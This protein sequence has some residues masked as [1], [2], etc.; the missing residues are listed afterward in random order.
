M[1]ILYLTTV[2][3]KSEVTS[4]IYADLMRALSQSHSVTVVALGACTEKRMQDGYPVY[5]QKAMPYYNTS[6]LK[7]GMA[8]LFLSS[9]FIRAIKNLPD[10]S[11]DVILFETPPPTIWRAVSFAKKKYGCPAYLMLKDIAP[12]NGVDLGIYSKHSLVYHFF[13]HAE[14]KLYRTADFIGCMSEA[15]LSCAAARGADPNRLEIFENTMEVGEKKPRGDEAIRRRYH[16]PENAVVCVFGGN[17]GR[18]QALPF[19]TDAIVALKDDPRFFFVLAGRGKE[20]EQTRQAKEK[21]NLQ[22]V[23][24]LD[25]LPQQEYDELLSVSDIG[26]VL[27][28]PRFTVPNYPS[29]ILKY[30]QYSLPIVAA[31]DDATDIGAMIEKQQIGL[32]GS[33]SDLPGFIAH[34]SMLAD[35]PDLRAQMGANGFRYVSEELSVSKS[36]ELLEGLF[37]VKARAESFGMLMQ[38][39]LLGTPVSLSS[40]KYGMYLLYATAVRHKTEALLYPSVAPFLPDELKGIWESAMQKT[41]I[42]QINMQAQ[43]RKT[44]LALHDAEI[45]IIALKGLVALPMY[46]HP[47]LR[48]MGDADLLVDAKDMEKID[49]VLQSLGYRMIVHEG[50]EYVY[51]RGV[52]DLDIHTEPF[53]SV[54]YNR[55]RSYYAKDTC[56]FDSAVGAYV[57]SPTVS[58]LYM[59]AHGAKTFLSKG[60]GL[61]Y[62][63]DM[64][65]L[66]QKQTIDWETL[67]RGLSDMELLDFGICLLFLCEKKLGIT[68]A[69]PYP[70][71][72]EDALA[73][74]LFMDCF[75]S[76]A[77]APKSLVQFYAGAAI[78]Q[79]FSKKQQKPF[80]SRLFS[81]RP[82]DKERAKKHPVLIPVF[83]LVHLFCAA[84]ERLFRLTHKKE[85]HAHTARRAALAKNLKL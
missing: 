54:K 52:L 3:E 30:M 12:Q 7:K 48:Y 40:G 32:W 31:T 18:P 58:L 67:W 84:K 77:G 49:R 66:V 71:P 5:T 70:K 72:T 55:I 68:K 42:R 27:L 56:T 65:L 39:A 29:R 1:R 81:L 11:F 78:S 21:Y 26:L 43:A 80:L 24:I 16:I 76:W 82:A 34:L 64:V 13:S 41:V 51:N 85:I 14:K 2:F 20:K 28:D 59:I 8:S 73:D 63:C 83:W 9:Y 22:N 33:S 10:S 50:H 47:E 37:D 45:F 53:G 74:R 6:L 17:M 62:L 25:A 79:D 15:N 60:L 75:S 35:D 44:L 23:L 36:V 61:K 38:H 46:P 57:P 69:I 19:L 4:T